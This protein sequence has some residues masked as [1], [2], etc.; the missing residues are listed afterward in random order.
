M[1]IGT[2]DLRNW[3]ALEDG[4]KEINPKLYSAALMIQDFVDDYTNR[5][6]EATRYNSD[7][8]F[9][10]LDGTGKPYIYV[11]QFPLS[12]VY[13]INIDSERAFGSGT[14]VATADI[15]W[16]PAGKI[17]SEAGYFTKGHRNVKIDYVAGFAPILNDTYNSSVS[18]YPIPTDLRQVMIEMAV[19]TVKEGITGIHSVSVAPGESPRFM[20]ML[21]NN[22]FWRQ[23]LDGYKNYSC[24]LSYN[25]D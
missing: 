23:V 8:S 15:F 18:T 22:T 14:E 17:V 4:D 12:Y 5:Q 10:Y 3:L 13:S 7:P 2:G 16:Y 25:D 21:G 11:P 19:E 9:T 24:G 6:M 1:L 20:K